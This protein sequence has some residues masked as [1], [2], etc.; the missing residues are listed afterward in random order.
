[1]LGEK[2]YYMIPFISGGALILY[3]LYMFKN[4]EQS[5]KKEKR[6]LPLEVAKVKKNGI[7]LIFLGILLILIEVFR[8]VILR[9]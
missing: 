4:P 1:M 8:R 2:I 5:V 7:I 9:T 3:G 6:D